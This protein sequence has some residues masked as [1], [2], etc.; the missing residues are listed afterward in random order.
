VTEQ[1]RELDE[2]DWEN[3]GGSAQQPREK[4]DREEF[5]SNQKQVSRPDDQANGEKASK[6]AGSDPDPSI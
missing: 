4:T 3:E 6:P 5:F 1:E 2:G